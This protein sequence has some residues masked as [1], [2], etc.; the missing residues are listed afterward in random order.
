MPEQS[1][2]S[3]LWA[4]CG[5]HAIQDGLVALQY[6]LLPVLALQFNLS[7]SQVGFLRAIGHTA[8]SSLEIPAGILAE[9]WGERR[10][11]AFGLVCAGTGYVGIANSTTFL[12]VAIG[13]L[14]AG[15]GA[16]FQHS[17]SSAII[18]NTFGDA[19]KRRS[20][21]TYNA[22]GDAGKLSF[23]AFFSFGI[24]AGLA[25]DTVVA[26]LAVTA[27]G[28]GLLVFK[29]IK[30]SDSPNHFNC[31]F[32][33]KSALSDHP[34]V[35]ISGKKRW[36][37]R[38]PAEFAKLSTI[39][40]LD[41]LIQAVFLTFLGFILLQKGASAAEASFAVV[42]A[43][44]GGMAGKFSCGRI[45]PVLGDRMTFR[46][47]Q[48]LTMLG[49]CLVIFLPVYALWIALPLVGLVIQ[50]TSTVTYGAVSDYL[51]SD[52]QSRGYALIYSFSGASSVA[53]P[54]LLG[55]LADNA[56]LGSVL[57]A[58]TIIAFVSMLFSDTLSAQR[59][60]HTA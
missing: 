6:V 57:I 43:L 7:Y 40:F 11:L 47:L 46:I 25:W 35:Q 9:R 3:T 23:T 39:V 27:I 30:P 50:G 59:L 44:L 4:C 12:W 45:A 48:S 16:G 33:G 60:G 14:I 8:M 42:V 56:G 38:Q 26:V 37:I 31:D 5:A 22:S 2:R 1:N 34:S 55:M 49:L 51:D 58:L 52:K 29:L 10:L 24:G 17:L 36:G 53:G 19:D 28:L 21:G 15:I 54:Y 41:S 20:L 18:V 32:E 13:L